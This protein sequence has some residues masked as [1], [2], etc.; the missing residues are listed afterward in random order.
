MKKN[1]H[2]GNIYKFAAQKGIAPD[3]I[4]DFSANIN[5]LGLSPSGAEAIAHNLDGL[6]HYPDPNN[7][8]LGEITAQRLGVKPENLLFGNGAA[9]LLFAVARLPGF[10][11][12]LIPAPGF[13]EYAEA[14]TAAGLRINS[15]TLTH[16]FY[17]GSDESAFVD[18]TVNEASAPAQ[19]ASDAGFTVSYD[20]LA[21]RLRQDYGQ[22]RC[23]VFMG[24]PNNPDG[25]L[26]NPKTI[27]NLLAAIREGNHL[28]VADESFMEFTDETTTLRFEAVENGHIVVLH[29]LTKFYAVPGLRLG[30]II[31]VPA[32]L[33][34]VKKS[35]PAWS[36][37]RLAQ[38]YGVAALQD[39]AYRT[40]TK[41]NTPLHRDWLCQQ[42]ATLGPIKVVRPSV[43]FM[44]CYWTPTTPTVE[45]LFHFLATKYILVRD[46]S[47]YENL[48][49]GW[50]RVAVKSQDNNEI[51]V[52]AIK[53]FCHEH[54]LLGTPRSDE[55]E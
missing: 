47:A 25:S 48:G 32:L 6:I 21:K 37:N 14:A 29:S 43:N 20:D 27:E 35:V 16:R 24:N 17:E 3:A 30:A 33:K 41:H 38:V 52:S 12:V 28:L 23:I 45:D 46:C 39:D 10:T 50:F 11:D 18:S 19:A 26:I 49:P 53:E 15:Y 1:V 54:N 7:T 34:A 31:G 44:L 8:D 51:L 42:M 9:E 55:M 5:P 13:S 4:I 40:E 22:K 36:V 2:G